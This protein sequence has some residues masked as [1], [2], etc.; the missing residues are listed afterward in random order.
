[1]SV[2]RDYGS[3]SKASRKILAPLVRQYGYEPHDGGGF[4]RR[5]HQWL[6]GFR[7][8][9]SQYGDGSFC[10][11]MGI[12]VP[13]L[14]VRWQMPKGDDQSFIVGSRL[15][16]MG[17][18]GRDRWLPGSNNDELVRSLDDVASWL[19]HVEPWFAQF[20]S[21]DDV[22]RVYRG[23]TNLTEIGHNAWHLQIMAANYGFLLAE[24][25]AN[26]EARRWLE[27]AE[28][29]M[30]LPVYFAPHGPGMFHEKVKGARL[31]KPSAQ[32]QR[33]LHAVQ[34]SLV[35]LQTHDG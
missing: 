26:D 7:L 16:E 3:F 24:A 30:S 34:E 4:A 27:E 21:L 28:R 35:G 29:L 32:E 22:A 2:K 10:I 25:N 19:G 5:R 14:A 20:Q 23:T 18:D 13:G 11:N 31:Q 9:Q 12:S 8:Q 1:M 33:E 6:E 17:L 15:S